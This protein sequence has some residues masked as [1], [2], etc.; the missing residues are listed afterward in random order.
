MAVN[1]LLARVTGQKPGRDRGSL[2][3]I[4]SGAS[5]TTVDHF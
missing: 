5:S 4:E 3:T 1:E 2:N